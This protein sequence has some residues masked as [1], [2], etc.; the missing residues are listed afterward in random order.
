M[1]PGRTG[2]GNFCVSRKELTR[3]AVYIRL[4]QGLASELS[5]RGRPS[6]R[7]QAG[8]AHARPEH[9]LTRAQSGQRIVVRKDGEER[10]DIEVVQV[11]RTQ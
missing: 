3:R 2:N 6:C 5:E 8:S 11:E 1:R 7:R 4:L 9:I 10:V